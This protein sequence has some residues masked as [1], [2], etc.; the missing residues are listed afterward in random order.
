MEDTIQIQTDANST[1]QITSEEIHETLEEQHKAD[2]GQPEGTPEQSQ[3]NGQNSTEDKQETTNEEPQKDIQQVVENRQQ[4]E[5]DVKDMLNSNNVNFDEVANEYA[6]NGELSKETMEKLNSI[7]LPKTVV[8]NYI[9]GLEAD[10]NA[11]AQEVMKVAGGEEGY[12]QMTAFI[13]SKGQAEVDSFNRLIATGDFGIIATGIR[14][15]LS[16]MTKTYGTNN[17]TILGSNGGSTQTQV[18]GFTSKA[19]MIEAMSDPRYG[20]DRAYTKEV[21]QKTIN[22]TN[23]F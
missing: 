21:E 19:Q 18:Q 17:R 8:D 22:S 10:A 2:Q 14:G 15:Y 11:F 20:K 13:Q 6:E 5:S 16:D 1:T 4:L 7:G 12:K 3:N 9:K 23:I